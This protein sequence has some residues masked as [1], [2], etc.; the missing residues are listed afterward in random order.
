MHNSHLIVKHYIRVT[1]ID[2]CA[3][4]LLF[5][6]LSND[7]RRNISNSVISKYFTRTSRVFYNKDCIIKRVSN[8]LCL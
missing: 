2:N 7:N 4:R 3:K 5:T 1:F 8:E 6:T